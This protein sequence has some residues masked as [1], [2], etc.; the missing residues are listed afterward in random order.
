MSDRFQ[1]VIADFLEEDKIETAVLG[2]IATLT[3]ASAHDENEL[4]SHVANADAII[5]FHDISRVGEPTFSRAKRCRCVVRAGV[6]FNN[7]DLE[8]ATRHGI[9]VCNVPDY[10]TEEVADHAIMLLLALARRLVPSHQAIREGTWDYRLATGAPRLRGNTLGLVGCGRIGTA[11]A[12]RAKAFGLDVLIQDPYLPNGIEKAL[13]VRRVRDL[14]ELLEQS[15]FVSLHC[16]L[17]AE[18]HHLIDRAAVARMQSGTLL[19]NTARGPLIDENALLE[20][21]ENAQIAAAGL[22][23]VEV[24]PLTDDRLRLHPKILLTPHT[25]FYSEEGYVELRA[26]AASEV[27][28]ILL[29]HEP[30]NPVNNPAKAPH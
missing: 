6:G 5:L 21:L 2:D 14:E 28:G 4:L 16:Y 26:K 10:G 8:S 22:D 23:V 20:G 15:E 24:E 1:V 17:N 29:G 25:A 13:G 30:R 19:V 18:T 9:Q 11:T 12:L 7:I 3:R 27:R